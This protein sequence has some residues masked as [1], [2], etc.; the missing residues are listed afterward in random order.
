M[1][2][3]EAL[4][5]IELLR[6]RVTELE[7]VVEKARG[8]DKAESLIG[9]VAN[10]PKY[11]PDCL[12]QAELDRNAKAEEL[13]EALAKLDDNP[14][15]TCEG[16]GEVPKYATCP[17]CE[18]SLTSPRWGGKWWVYHCP[19]CKNEFADDEKDPQVPCPNCKEVKK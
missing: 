12:R 4:A 11:T 10:N 14:C 16:E 1:D 6:T 19:R 7:Q 17:L 3:I 13:H 15:Q 9:E 2:K 18:H 8:W 5:E